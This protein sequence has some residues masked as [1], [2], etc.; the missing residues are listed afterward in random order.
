MKK[1]ITPESYTKNPLTGVGVLSGFGTPENPP[2]Y[3]LE[4]VDKKTPKED[5]HPGPGM[6][7]LNGR[8]Q[9]PEA[10]NMLGEGL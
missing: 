1:K 8:V 4:E 2:D 9:D 5:T 7:N 6:K 3:N 10:R